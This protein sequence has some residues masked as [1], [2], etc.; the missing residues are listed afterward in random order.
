MTNLDKVY[1]VWENIES[2][3]AKQNKGKS[4]YEFALMMIGSDD[5]LVKLRERVNQDFDGMAES[6]AKL[7]KL[8]SVLERAKMRLKDTDEIKDLTDFVWNANWVSSGVEEEEF[9]LLSCSPLSNRGYARTNDLLKRGIFDS[10]FTLKNDGSIESVLV[11]HDGG[12][13]LTFSS[14]YQVLVW[15]S[16]IKADET[17]DFYVR[18]YAILNAMIET[19]TL[20]LPICFLHSD[21]CIGEG[22]RIELPV[23][24]NIG[25]WRSGVTSVFQNKVKTPKGEMFVLQIL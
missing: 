12:K 25:E 17:N 21:K 13:L 18:V 11:K 1:D 15:M 7:N 5:S 14:A 10:T 19:K 9:T 6:T 20:K 22:R 24:S 4:R 23:R 3:Y 8:F 16:E 2:V